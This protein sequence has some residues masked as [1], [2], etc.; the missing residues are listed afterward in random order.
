VP[1]ISHEPALFEAITRDAQGQW[2]SARGPLIKTLSLAQLQAFDVGR[3][4]PATSYGRQFP[5]QVPRDGQRIPTLA[6]LFRLVRQLGA[7]DVQFD[8]ETKV[9]PNRPDDTVAPEVFVD[10][11][12]ATIREAGMTQRVMV[13]SFDWR[14][15]QLIQKRE[16]GLRTVYLTSQHRNFNTVADGSWTAGLLLAQHAS[17][18]HMVKAC[19]GTV[20][21]PNFTDIDADAVRRAQALGLKVIPWTVN[22]AAD[23]DLLI[24]WGV[25]GIISDYPDRV[26]EAMKQRGMALPKRL[27]N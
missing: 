22:N 2:L 17:V 24:G 26:R 19:G 25:D 6:S 1:V 16:P 9:F 10:I 11:L 5:H 4:N 13:Q 21:S 18:A 7:N 12:L 15:L 8:I 23:A 14:T 27:K 3:S 20:W